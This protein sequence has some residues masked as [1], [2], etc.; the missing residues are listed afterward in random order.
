VTTGS[1]HTV[2]GSRVP[3]EFAEDV[4]QAAEAEDRSV[5]YLIRRALGRELER[6]RNGNADE[7]R[8]TA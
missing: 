3:T 7:P 1:T 2:I 6:V 5:S 4:R 8:A